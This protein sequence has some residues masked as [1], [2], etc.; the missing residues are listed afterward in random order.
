[1]LVTDPKQRASLSEIM[2]HPWIVK[3]FNTPP[4]NYLPHRE[5]L[6]LPLDPDVIGSMTGF[7]FGPSEQ[8]SEKLTKI[9]ESEDYQQAT[10]L[11]TKR[12]HTQSHDPERKRGVF[13]FYKRR[14][15]ISSRDTL[16]NS[17]SEVLQ[18]GLDP[19]NAYNPLVSVYYLVREKQEREQAKKSLKTPN[20]SRQ[21][22]E[23]LLKMPDLPVPEAALVNNTTY[24]MAGEKPTGGRSRPR[25][26]TQ[27][28]DEAKEGLQN[29]NLNVPGNS[30][31]PSGR[32]PS[33]EQMTPKKENAATGL[34]R[35]LSA[36]RYKDGDRDK[37]TLPV[38][39]PTSAPRPVE[40]SANSRKSFSI[41]RS[42]DREAITPVTQTEREKVKQPEL[43]SPPNALAETT[44]RL[45]GIGRSTSVNSADIRR[46]FSRR[47]TSDTY[48]NEP[49]QTGNSDRSSTRGQMG[50]TAS[51]D[52]H[53]GPR[54]RLSAAKIPSFSNRRESLHIQRP[55]KDH[56]SPLASPEEIR[57]Q[58]VDREEPSAPIDGTND[59]MKPVYLKG[60]FSVSTTSSKPLPVI[61]ADLIRVLGQLGVQYREVKGGFSCRQVPSIDLNKVVDKV[62]TSPPQIPTSTPAHRRRLSFGGFINSDKDREDVKEQHRSPQTPRS[63]RQRQAR[64]EPSFTNSEESYESIGRVDN[65]S[66]PAGE[67]TTQVQNDFGQSMVLIFEI[68]VVKVPLLS[69]HGIQFKKVD[70]GT[71]QYKN[72][73]QKIL[74]ELRL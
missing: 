26:R 11:A 50:D 17:S 70:G 73:A 8:I 31:L 63:L 10:R 51:D 48:S 30:G 1:M 2:N 22:S 20:T 27:G 57:R 52:V 54:S 14:N 64:Y 59:G 62:P 3:G 29:L 21:S 71:W 65:R 35:R 36:R 39:S 69:L 55:G 7:D 5:P 13:E 60:L 19:I 74:D 12:L 28:E 40:T 25:A 6:Q 41:R 43:L 4:E 61:R 68:F 53:T 67:T 46:R 72:M 34:F 66:K 24:E 9:I 58:N 42:R 56:V 49:P 33:S 38:T 45:K 47:I 16:I 37:N 44:R 23:R 18:I 32:L 15:S